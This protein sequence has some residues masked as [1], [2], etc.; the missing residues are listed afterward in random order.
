[1]R[2][3]CTGSL[4]RNLPP[5]LSPPLIRW[6]WPSASWTVFSK[7][8]SAFASIWTD[9]PPS[10]AMIAA[11]VYSNIWKSVVSGMSSPTGIR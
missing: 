10:P 1:M 6:D 7:I 2:S 8:P 3:T 11:P 5:T 4:D 9:A